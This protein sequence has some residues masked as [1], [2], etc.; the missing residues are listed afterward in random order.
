AEPG[1]SPIIPGR[2]TRIGPATFATGG[3][4]ANTGLA[5]HRLGVTTALVG[6]VGDD[7]FG[8][9]VLD[10][11]RRRD[12]ALAKHMRV[13]DDAPTSYTLVISP[14]GV[15]R[16]FLHCPGANDRFAADDVDSAAF[17]DAR[18][19]HFGYPPLMQRIQN[20]RGEE[21]RTLFAG[22]RAAGLTTSLDM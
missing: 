1:P 21:L 2:L 11:L 16:A 8:Q 12:R 3:A 18:L 6:R 14:P 19:L 9:A 20:D 13:T 10:L 7:V 17:P 4:V 15:D 22:A 5:L